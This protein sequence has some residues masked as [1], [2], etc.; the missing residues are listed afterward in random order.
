MFHR[1]ELVLG[2][3]RAVLH[4]SRG[5]EVFARALA[6][7]LQVF[8]LQVIPIFHGPIIEFLVLQNLQFWITSALLLTPDITDFFFYLFIPILI[9]QPLE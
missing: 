4:P 9:T 7:L 8:A 1:I 6:L 5:S 3:K 2:E